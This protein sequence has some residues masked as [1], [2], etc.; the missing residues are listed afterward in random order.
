[1]NFKAFVILIVIGTVVSWFSWGMSLFYFDP[2]QIGGLGFTMFYLS[3]FLA[4]SGTIFLV[5]D[6]MKARV[7]SRQLIFFRLRTSVRHSIFFTILIVGWLFLRS[8]D[9]LQWWNLLIFLFV[10]TA[11]EFFFISIQKQNNFYERTD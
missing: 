11:L 5:I 7:M 8:Q 9:L 10:L 4:L 2:Q 3:L 1:M 6:W